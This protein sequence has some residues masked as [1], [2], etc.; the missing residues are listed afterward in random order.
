MTLGTVRTGAGGVRPGARAD[1]TGD[2]LV[3]TEV[4]VKQQPLRV[5]ATFRTPEGASRRS[6]LANEVI[7]VVRP[8]LLT[9]Q[10]DPA[11]RLSAWSTG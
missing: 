1:D 4:A 3:V 7:G 9:G 6:R 11:C 2:E 8:A 10:R 5:Y